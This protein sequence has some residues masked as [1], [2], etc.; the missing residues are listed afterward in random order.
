VRITKFEEYGLRLILR[1]A[2]DGGQ[3]TIRELAERERIPEATVAKVIGRLRAAA[4][5][6]A[7]RGRKGGYALAEPPAELT[8]A[9]IVEAFDE[10]L[11]DP[12]FCQRMAPGDAA[13][14]RAP[15]CGLRPVWRGLTAVVGDFLAGITVADVL[16]GGAAPRRGVLPLAAGQRM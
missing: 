6:R 14:S 11:Y 9:R 3:L 16:A 13:C 2:A 8:I 15:S 10:R 4:L 7:V 1:L 5:V 12:G